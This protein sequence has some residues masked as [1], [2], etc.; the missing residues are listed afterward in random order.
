MPGSKT[1]DV[2]PSV[3]RNQS[4]IKNV[5]MDGL[6]GPKG[7]GLVFVAASR[8]DPGRRMSHD[9][10]YATVTDLAISAKLSRFG[11]LVLVTRLSN[12][13]PVGGATV[14]VREQGGSG[15]LLTVTTDARG[16]AML[17]ADRFQPVKPDGA[18]DERYVLFAR[19]GDDWTYREAN[20]TV[21]R[22]EMP[23]MDLAA[24]MPV[25]GMLFTD[26]GIYRAGES[27]R[28]KGVFRKDNPKGMETPRGRDMTIRAYDPEGETLF[29][30]TGKL[31]AF[32]EI[33]VEIPIPATSRLGHVQIEAIAD[34]EK[35]ADSWTPNAASITSSAR[36]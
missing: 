28:V 8:P 33:A 2:R 29:E 1:E 20:D 5:G 27:I 14:A 12:G 36:R 6:V 26:R 7:H 11:S 22:A 19:S 13:K 34:G 9:L 25:Y 32:G 4:A 21:S 10:R 30:H 17:P 16:I 23:Y 35:T 15:E 31:G 24:R 18:I 3:P